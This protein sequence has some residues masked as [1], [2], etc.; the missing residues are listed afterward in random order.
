[1]DTYDSLKPGDSFDTFSMDCMEIQKYQM[2]RYPYLFLDQ[3][4]EIQPGKYAKGFKNYTV[5]EWFFP[6]HYPTMP[7]VPGLLQLEALSHLAIL[8]FLTLPGNQ[9]MITNSLRVNNVKFLS[10]VVPG[11]K[12]MMEAQLHSWKRG[13]AKCSTQG[14]VDEEEV[15]SADWVFTIPSILDKYNPSKKDNDTNNK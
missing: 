2:N 13:I 11:Q 10:R 9:G 15:S 3:V 6:V 8:T 5:N 14:Y 4:T 7:N 1:M 12:F